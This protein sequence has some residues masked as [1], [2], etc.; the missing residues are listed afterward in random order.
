MDY[1]GLER[2]AKECQK[3]VLSK[4]R[5]NVVFGDGSTSA[6]IMILG[7]APGSNEDLQGKPFVGKAG[8]LLTEILKK[9]GID[10]KDVFISNIVKCRPPGNR[11]PLPEEIKACYPYLDSQIEYIKPKVILPLG[12]HSSKLVLE[13][14]NQ[15]FEGI[16]K[17]HGKIHQ[18]STSWGELLVIPMYHP[19]ATIYNQSLKPVLEKDFENVRN[20][21]K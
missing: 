6:K 4:T 9:V 12:R 8:Q 15:T 18:V 17:D 20:V 1:E 21:F 10:R 13:K 14:Y 5:T 2:Q 19:A 3:C 16:S 7:E 11:D